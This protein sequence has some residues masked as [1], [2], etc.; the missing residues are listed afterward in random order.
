M[1][2]QV[3]RAVAGDLDGWLKCVGGL[4]AEDSGTRDRFSDQSWP[5]EHGAEWF[6]GGLEAAEQLRL[7][8]DVEGR[9]AGF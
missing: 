4:F 8:A 5:T 6:R 2:A 1:Q 7:V 3:R 9:V